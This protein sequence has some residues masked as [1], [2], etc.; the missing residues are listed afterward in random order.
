MKKISIQASPQNTQKD[1]SGKTDLEKS[2]NLFFTFFLTEPYLVMSM[3][4]IL[5]AGVTIVDYGCY[6]FGIMLTVKM[7]KYIIIC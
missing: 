5:V 7:W 2:Q 3:M 1:T 6:N 4:T